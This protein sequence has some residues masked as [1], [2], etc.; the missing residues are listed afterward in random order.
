MFAAQQELKI[1]SIC[2]LVQSALGTKNSIKCVVDN[3]HS[4]FIRET[5]MLLTALNVQHP[6]GQF[7]ISVCQSF[8][9][10]HGCG[11]KTLLYMIGMFVK[12]CRNLKDKGVPSDYIDTNLDVILDRCCKKADEIRIDFSKPRYKK[13]IQKENYSKQNCT[14][15]GGVVLE[16][17]HENSLSGT[18]PQTLEMDQRVNCSRKGIINLKSENSQ[19]TDEPDHSELDWLLDDD[20][21]REML[22][23]NKDNNSD[24]L[25]S[26]QQPSHFKGSNVK[27]RPQNKV[28]NDCESDD[29]FDD[30]FDTLLNNTSTDQ[31]QGINQYS[32]VLSVDLKT[33][34]P[35][36]TESK[37]GTDLSS[38]NKLL[39]SITSSTGKQFSASKIL[40]SSRHYKT[41]H[42]SVSQIGDKSNIE[43]TGH[44]S[45]GTIKS[46]HEIPLEKYKEMGNR[47]IFK[48]HII[49]DEFVDNV[50][51]KETG[52]AFYSCSE[53]GSCLSRKTCIAKDVPPD[54]V[55]ENR[56]A[57]FISLALGLSHGSEEMMNSL[58]DSLDLNSTQFGQA[59][60]NCVHSICIEGPLSQ[61]PITVPGIVV[62]A[63]TEV[64]D[65]V[66]KYDQTT[67]NTV[68]INGDI[69][70]N[71]KHI[72]YKKSLPAKQVLS[73][74]V[75]GIEDQR[76]IEW[77]NTIEEILKMYSIRCLIVKGSVCNE[78]I[79]LCLKENIIVL[80]GVYY[81][82][83]QGLANQFDICMMAY[84]TNVTDANVCNVLV[85]PYCDDWMLKPYNHVIIK[86]DVMVDN[87]KTIVLC[88]PSKNGCDLLEQEF[89]RCINVLSSAMSL[90]CVLPGYA[91]TEEIIAQHLTDNGQ[92]Q[93]SDMYLS[94]VSEE[95]AAAF[96]EFVWTVRRNVQDIPSLDNRI[97]DDYKT[98]ISAW[99]TSLNTAMTIF[100]TDSYIINDQNQTL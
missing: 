48:N 75:T 45:N 37:Q 7:I 73:D 17:K 9:Q 84:L 61:T 35:Q 97:V 5:S 33:K 76:N 43:E 77:L 14:V 59:S 90:G 21:S 28:V 94:V 83:L 50:Q 44:V 13:N 30:C 99:K 1:L 26:R 23:I 36:P 32:N 58:I 96:Q 98:K 34:S 27:V 6:V 29:E 49:D 91:K 16:D 87:F 69:S 10:Q 64:L 56:E 81:R 70:Y 24:V 60:I 72:G 78:V 62:K 19:L 8:H 25:Y 53:G 100:H 66:T 89:Q 11:V 4:L 92:E 71:Y 3:N 40:N 93:S 54:I 63:R 67:I 46:T 20:L 80:D 47:R 95:V 57:G 2:S 39:K 65:I 82:T 18:P 85:K 22:G 41:I 74:R 51:C 31:V 88:H 68:I 52:T 86:G 38:V 55:Q 12:V 42:S 15:A 79:D